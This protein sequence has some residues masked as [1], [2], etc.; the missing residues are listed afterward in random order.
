MLHFS[1]Q[2]QLDQFHDDMIPL[3]RTNENIS[4]LC[5]LGFS[6][7]WDFNI[8]QSNQADDTVFNTSLENCETDRTGF[9]NNIEYTCL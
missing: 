7:V 5:H 1:F 2:M 8:F 9:C 3:S 4:Y 6:D